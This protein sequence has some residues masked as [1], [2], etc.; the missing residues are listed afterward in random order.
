MEC[1]KCG[2]AMSAEDQA[3]PRCEGAYAKPVPPPS[4][5]PTGAGAPTAPDVVEIFVPYRNPNALAAYYVGLFAFIPF[6]GAIIGVAAFVLGLRGLKLA[7]AHP[8]AR[9]ASHAWVG[10]VLGGIWGLFYWAVIIVMVSIAIS[11]PETR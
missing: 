4:A 9:G 3:C 5:P 2:Y 6:L 11:R 1:P 10:I 7:R 8:E